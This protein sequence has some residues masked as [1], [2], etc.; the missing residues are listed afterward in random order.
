MVPAI[1]E[2]GVIGE[3]LRRHDTAQVRSENPCDDLRNAGLESIEENLS[4]T[5]WETHKGAWGGSGVVSAF[6]SSFK[7][8]RLTNGLVNGRHCAGSLGSSGCRRGGVGDGD[9]EGR[10]SRRALVGKELKLLGDVKFQGRSEPELPEEKQTSSKAWSE[11]KKET[12][13]EQHGLARHGVREGAS[14]AIGFAAS[15][16]S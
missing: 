10:V 13:R 5:R 3:T 15:R 16:L 4:R 7:Q 2:V 8:S 12:T 1:V 11:G 9:V 6:S 14:I